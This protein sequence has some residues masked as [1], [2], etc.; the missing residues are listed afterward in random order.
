M[1]VATGPGRVGADTVMSGYPFSV[2]F[3]VN[4]ISVRGIPES[5]ASYAGGMTE[6]AGPTRLSV[7]ADAQRDV[8]PDLA[9]L[10]ASVSV[11]AES[12]AAARDGAT[13]ALAR[14]TGT[15]AELGGAVRTVENPGAP[16]TW[17]VRGIRS[18]AGKA[19]SGPRFRANAAVGIEV[20]EFALVAAA[21]TAIER[22][23]DIRIDSIRWRVDDDNPGWALVRA[24]AIRAALRKG[25]DYADALGGA[26]QSVE[27]VADAGLLG[28]R[29][30]SGRKSVV[31]LGLMSQ[32]G[33]ALVLDPVPQTISA[34]IEARF[35]A[36]TGPLPTR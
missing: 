35:L 8:A 20:R 9:H 30:S 31:S 2:R 23:D 19:R 22:D 32:S 16:L 11:V 25:Q 27:H 13:S 4:H 14:L 3:L 36:T 5:P 33:E 34:V 26:V 24:D 18:W 17:T 21:A 29:D 1:A 7:R 10:S 12:S 6:T 15:L 28:D